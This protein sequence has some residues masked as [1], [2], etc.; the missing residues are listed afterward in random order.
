MSKLGFNPKQRHAPGPHNINYLF[1]LLLWALLSSLVRLMW[2]I[3]RIEKPGLL[4]KEKLK[5]YC[6]PGL[7]YIQSEKRVTLKTSKLSISPESC[8][9]LKIRRNRAVNK[10][11]QW[12]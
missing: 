5:C 11:S 4:E 7:N 9:R 1:L 6:C 3:V 8:L 2:T 12:L 10:F